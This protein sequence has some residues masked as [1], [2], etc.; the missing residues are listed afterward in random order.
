MSIDENDSGLAEALVGFA[1]KKRKPRSMPQ[2]PF[3]RVPEFLAAFNNILKNGFFEEIQLNV[4]GK[5]T[6]GRIYSCT[7]IATGCIPTSKRFK[8]DGCGTLIDPNTIITSCRS[9]ANRKRGANVTTTVE[10]TDW[11]LWDADGQKVIGSKGKRTQLF[12]HIAFNT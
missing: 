8:A 4:G 10:T 3:A 9:L 12:F 5:M 11:P 6:E 7:I 2:D 1:P